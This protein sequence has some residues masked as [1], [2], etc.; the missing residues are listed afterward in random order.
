MPG[1]HQDRLLCARLCPTAEQKHWKTPWSNLYF[2]LFT[3]YLST[4][5]PR[6]LAPKTAVGSRQH[7]R[8]K[9]RKS[10]RSDTGQR[11]QLISK[12]LLLD[13]IQD[14]RRQKPP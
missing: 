3:F 8:R 2:L 6:F 11:N 7:N 14:V 9:K 13:W 5:S 10:R 12:S 4:S 1:A